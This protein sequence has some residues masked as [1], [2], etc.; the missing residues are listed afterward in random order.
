MIVYDKLWETMKNKGVT[1]YTL[2]EKHNIDTRTI[3]RLK[4]NQNMTTNTLNKLCD[5]L[6]CKLEDIATHVIAD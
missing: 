1:T 4:A 3:R 6:G 2:I 5:I